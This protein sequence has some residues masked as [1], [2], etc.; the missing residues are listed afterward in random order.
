M[1]VRCHCQPPR[2]VSLKPRSI[3]ARNPYQTVNAAGG[4]RSV[5]SSHGSR[6]EAAHQASKVARSGWVFK[7]VPLPCHW[8]PG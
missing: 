7:A 1:R 8:E 2:F 4:G 5:S 6:L 3:Q